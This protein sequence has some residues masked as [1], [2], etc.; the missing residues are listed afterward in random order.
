MSIMLTYDDIWTHRTPPDCS[1]Y[2]RKL[3]A[4]KERQWRPQLICLGSVTGSNM[5]SEL[6]VWAGVRSDEVK[7]VLERI[8][9]KNRKQFKKEIVAAIWGTSIYHTWR[10][11]NWVLFRRVHVH[12]DIVIAQNGNCRKT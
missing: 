4:L 10:V 11:R 3:N 7:V 2:W 12:T 5:C 6:M 8:K 1:W 9:Q